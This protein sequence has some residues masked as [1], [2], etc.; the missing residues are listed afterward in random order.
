MAPSLYK[1]SFRVSIDTDRVSQFVSLLRQEEKIILAQLD[2]DVNSATAMALGRQ[3][4]E[5]HSAAAKGCK[6]GMHIP[7]HQTQQ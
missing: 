3:L 2:V 6:D 5:I 1:A 7:S 4:F